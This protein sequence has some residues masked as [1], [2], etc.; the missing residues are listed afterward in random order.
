[1]K[2]AWFGSAVFLL[3]VIALLAASDSSVKAGPRVGGHNP[4]IG[5]GSGGSSTYSPPPAY[6]VPTPA[7]PTQAALADNSATVSLYYSPSTATEKPAPAYIAV[8][9]TANAEIWFDSEKTSQTGSDRLFV[10]PSVP[11]DQEYTYKVRVV[12]TQDGR[13]VERTRSVAVRAGD[14]ATLDFLAAR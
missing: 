2:R 13:K 14:R 3:A 7:A 11:L 9:V 4:P 6:V 5:G 1:M 8:R 12:W 10:T